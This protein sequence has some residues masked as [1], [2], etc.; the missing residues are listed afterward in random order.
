MRRLTRTAAIAGA[1]LATGAIASTAAAVELP[2][3]GE[4]FVQTNGPR[5]PI[6][7]GDWYTS[8]V[9]SEGGG[10]HYV[11][12]IA[13]C[14]WPEDMPLHVDLYSPEMNYSSRDAK[15]H[16]EKRG[17]WRD[18]TYFE[19]YEAGTER[20]GPKQPGPRADGSMLRKVYK[21]TRKAEGWVRFATIDDPEPCGQYLMRVATQKD[22]ENSWRLRLGADD[23]ADP[24]NA[25]PAGYDDPD[26]VPASG[27]EPTY[28]IE[29]LAFQ[30]EVDTGQCHTFS[31]YAPPGA[32]SLTWHSFDMDRG[33]P[34][35]VRPGT[36][37]QLRLSYYGPDDAFDPEASTPGRNPSNHPFPQMS[38]NNSW[39]GMGARRDLRVGDRFDNPETGWWRMVV[40]TDDHNQYISEGELIEDDPAVPRMAFD[41]T[42]GQDEIAPGDSSTYT[43]SFENRASGAGAGAAAAVVI[44]DRL[45]AATTFGTCEIAAPFS[46]SCALEGGLVR[47]RLDE[48]VGAGES[49]EIE[50]RVTVS[51]DAAPGSTLRNEATLG[52]EDTMGNP[53]PRLDAAD[54][55]VV[56]D[57]GF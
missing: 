48:P 34:G 52:Y 24:T 10:Y 32:A 50:V 29:R 30:H 23:D 3:H 2:G 27:D 5:S 13:A 45:P 49:G 17:R 16:D 55:T 18:K 38:G 6:Q 19:L 56:A 33:N 26:R 41:K 39:N 12:L 20:T 25:P 54:E 43:L 14:E 31:K 46:G 21:P 22:D 8:R 57:T 53:F 35:V 9:N 42:D 44:E 1:C 37:D 51:G 15:R 47:A 7:H 11:K 36:E 40:C 4:I 28:E